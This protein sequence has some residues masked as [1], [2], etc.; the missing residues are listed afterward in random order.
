MENCQNFTTWQSLSKALAVIPQ[1]E[2]RSFMGASP[3][4]C[5]SS[6]SRERSEVAVSSD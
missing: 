4:S 6:R 2:S 1:P 5:C 3:L